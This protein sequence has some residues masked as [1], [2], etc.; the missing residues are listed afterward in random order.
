MSDDVLHST[1]YYIKYIDRA[2]LD[3][4]QCRQYATFDIINI[5][6]W[7]RGSQVKPLYLVL[8]SLCLSLFWESRDKGNLKNLPS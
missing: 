5:L 8:F 4:L 1:Q 3:N 6:T 2:I 7:L